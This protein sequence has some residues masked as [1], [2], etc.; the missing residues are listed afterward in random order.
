MEGFKVR[1]FTGDLVTINLTVQGINHVITV[2]LLLSGAEGIK[3]SNMI[4]K[5]FAHIIKMRVNDL[6]FLL[7]LLP[8]RIKT[9]Y[10]VL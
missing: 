3:E 7:G 5:V 8:F 1:L 6:I 4:V 9:H 2:Q 10:Q